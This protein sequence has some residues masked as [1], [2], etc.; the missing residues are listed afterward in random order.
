MRHFWI[1]KYRFISTSEL[2]KDIKKETQSYDFAQTSN[3]LTEIDSEAKSYASLCSPDQ[4][5]FSE[6]SQ[7]KK[8]VIEILTNI[9]LFDVKQCYTLMLALYRAL[10]SKKIPNQQFIEI[11]TLIENFTFVYI[12]ILEGRT[13]S[14]EEIF[15]SSALKI[16]RSDFKYQDWVKDL[17]NE[18]IRLS[19]DYNRFYEELEKITYISHKSS[20]IRYIFTKIEFYGQNNLLNFYNTSIEHI[21]PDCGGDR[22]VWLKLSADEKEEEY[23]KNSLGNLTLLHPDDNEFL[24]T[25]GYKIKIEAYKK[26]KAGITSEIPTQ[27]PEHWDK[28]TILDRRD[29]LIEFIRSKNIWKI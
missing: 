23:L 12:V 4:A 17:K 27:Y 21:Y 6:F 14:L 28:K 25:D 2:F 19:I 20:I 1:S 29:K 13:S 24:D 3:F 15:S 18:L 10:N 9:K 26:C 22:K 8:D 5:D 11:L 16:K 7:K